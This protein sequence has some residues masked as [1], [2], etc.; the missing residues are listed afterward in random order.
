MEV[1]WDTKENESYTPLVELHRAVEQNTSESELREY[2]QKVIDL[3]SDEA[4][5]DL[6][7]LAY[8]IRDVR[9]G[10]GRRD[11]FYI[12]LT[13]IYEVYPD[14]VVRLLEIVPEYGT[15]KD[16]FML[17]QQAHPI[18][19]RI[20][21]EIAGKQ[22]VEDEKRYSQ[23]LPISLLAKWAPREQKQLSHLAKG[24]AHFL[25]KDESASH[26]QIMSN[27]RRRIARLNLAMNT[28]ET[29]ECA[30]RWDEIVPEN[31]PKGALRIKK[32]AYI[33]ETPDRYIKE[34]ANLK[35]MICRQNFLYY[36]EV[37]SRPEFLF[38]E[39]RY[40]KVRAIT[41]EWIRGGWRG[42]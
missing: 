7:V 18:P 31:I 15:W 30:K 5:I 41:R 27:Y 1:L 9:G 34:P 32:R 37:S 17:T 29:L 26:A 21:Y 6:I 12:L 38:D 16:M 23:G 13:T 2:T 24:F 33:N 25:M 42:T 8:R 35:R 40:D 36:F 3:K 11:V 28:V 4:L 19:E 20:I 10:N 39:Y 22:L 14:L